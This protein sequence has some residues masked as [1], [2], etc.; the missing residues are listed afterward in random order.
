MVR[1]RLE[2]LISLTSCVGDNFHDKDGEWKHGR[3]EK[4]ETDSVLRLAAVL[5]VLSSFKI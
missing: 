3:L 1:T 4:R 2:I 5:A